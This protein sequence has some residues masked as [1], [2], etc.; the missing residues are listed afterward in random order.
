MS[1]SPTLASEPRASSTPS[2]TTRTRLLFV[3]LILLL[4]FGVRGLTRQFMQAHLDDPGWFQSGTYALFDRSAQNILDGKA[5]IFWIDDPAETDGAIYPPGYPAWLALVYTVTGERSAAATQRLQWI[6]DALAVLLVIGIGV[7]AF[8]WSVGLMAG[9][10][11]AFSPLLSLAGTTPLADAPTSWLVVG[12]SWMLLLAYQ[13]RSLGWAIVA[14]LMLGASCWLR[15]NGLLLG[16]FWAGAIVLLFGIP[17]RTRLKLAGGV[18]VGVIV[19]VTPLIVRNAVAFRAFV[20]AGLGM[21][22]NL[23]EGIGE[24]DRAREFGAVF[25]D[26]ALIEEERREMGVAPDAKFNLYYPDGVRRD[27]ERA[28]RAMSVIVRNPIWY[29]GVMLHRMW[30]MLK[31]AGEPLP[32]YGSAGINVTSTKTLPE[33]KRGGVLSLVVNVLG[34][35]QSISRYV[36]LPLAVFGIAV[37]FRSDWRI[38]LLMLATVVYYLGPGTFAHTELRYVLPMHCVLGVFAGVGVTFVWKRFSRRSPGE[39]TGELKGVSV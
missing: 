11:A 25:G 36:L 6:L 16:F 3:V 27:R 26:Q 19:L 34:M 10:F 24:T 23:W 1:A 5:S 32:Y 7:T 38:T 22:T 15:I 29:A 20:P 14:G 9:L 37:G 8:Q 31:V 2:S 35:V 18:L 39:K 28:R 12:G 4:A 17:K 30:G 21:G 33:G 13:R